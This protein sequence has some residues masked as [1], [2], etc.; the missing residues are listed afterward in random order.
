[1]IVKCRSGKHA[2][3]LP[4]HAPQLWRL[5]QSEFAPW[6]SIRKIPETWGPEVTDQYIH[7]FVRITSLSSRRLHESM[8]QQ[9]APIWDAIDDEQFA[10]ALQL[11][12]KTQKRYRTSN[13]TLLGLQGLCLAKENRIPEAL[14]V[15]ESIRKAA[16]DSKETYQT[17]HDILKSCPDVRVSSYLV[18]T[19]E[20]GFRLV[21]SEFMARFWFME[22]VRAGK[23]V[24]Q[25]KA[26]IE[27][28]KGF[29][30][31]DYFYLVLVSM[32]LVHE[33]HAEEKDKKLLGLLM[34]RMISKAAGNTDSSE[35]PSIQSVEEFYLYLDILRVLS[36]NE[37][38]L[39]ALDGYHG[40]EYATNHEFLLLKLNLLAATGNHEKASQLALTALQTNVDDWLVFKAFVDSCIGK[41]TP[42][43][44]IDAALTSC[45]DGKPTRNSLLARVYL[46]SLAPG[47]DS[48]AEV[49]RTYC[50]SFSDR[51]VTFEDLAPYTSLLSVSEKSDFLTALSGVE[52]L[53]G[54]GKV[55][56][57]T[58]AMKFRLRFL[59]QAADSLSELISPT[60]AAYSSAL[61]YGSELKETDNQCGDDL[62]LVAVQRI[63]KT[64]EVESSIRAITLLEHALTKSKH[65]F[66]L[67]LHLIWLYRRIGAWSAAF[68]HYQSL[69][70]KHI[71]RDTLSYLLLENSVH[72]YLS[73]LQVSSLKESQNI[74][75]ANLHETPDMICQAYENKT[76]SKIAEFMDFQTRLH[77]SVWWIESRLSIWTLEMMLDKFDYTKTFDASILDGNLYDNKSRDVMLDI[78][79]TSTGKDAVHHASEATVY[80]LRK[81]YRKI[82]MVQAIVRGQSSFVTVEEPDEPLAGSDADCQI[83]DLVEILFDSKFAKVPVRA[84]EDP[85]RTMIHSITAVPTVSVTARE[86]NLQELNRLGKI[87]ELL[88]LYSLVLPH[89]KVDLK[90]TT[91]LLSGILGSTRSYLETLRQEIVAIDIAVEIP[92]EVHLAEGFLQNV[93]KKVKDGR[94]EGVTCLLGVVK[95]IKM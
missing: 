24:A 84:L 51:L 41:H 20:L 17:I 48:L 77:K 78:H 29:L 42:S 63:A 80:T 31:R 11:V 52:V 88:K 89:L 25:R 5:P 57:E 73:I 9:L 65:N 23:L 19:M 86:F 90:A 83:C 93:L 40:K 27:L 81:N 35:G 85:L 76:Y 33:R 38:A 59:S 68:A 82:Q 64:D 55:I 18:E 1:M 69:G 21:K 71:Q 26:A 75:Y 92:P 95:G 16:P 6:S 34:Y 43:E 56:K 14:Q 30:A 15:C 2:S 50:L 49:L 37:E 66:Q 67:R 91:A 44:M 32:L 12:E 10:Y 58:N 45:F 53:T 62:L 74:Y 79:S 3:S 70:L 22:T 72:E 13:K 87:V 28:Q 4:G 94:R 46:T 60:L 7:A 61:Q 8:Q 47:K 54:I 39:A 36:K